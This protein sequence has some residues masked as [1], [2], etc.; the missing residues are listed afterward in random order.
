MKGSVPCPSMLKDL[1]VMPELVEVFGD[2]AVS[3]V[4]I[5]KKEEHQYSGSKGVICMICVNS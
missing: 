5:V 3:S 4:L 2:A 1:L